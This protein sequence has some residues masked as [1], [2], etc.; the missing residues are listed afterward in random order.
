MDN[1]ES[2]SRASSAGTYENSNTDSEDTKSE[3]PQKKMGMG[4]IYM[5]ALF[6]LIFLAGAIFS[7]SR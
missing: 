3:S 7:M 1:E 6:W 2:K 5:L 4:L